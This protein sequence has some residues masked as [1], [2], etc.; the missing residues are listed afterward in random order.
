MN[1]QDHIQFLNETLET[2][3]RIGYGI[4]DTKTHELIKF[5]KNLSFYNEL[6]DFKSDLKNIY[7]L[8]KKE[9]KITNEFQHNLDRSFEFWGEDKRY[10]ITKNENDVRIFKKGP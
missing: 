5:F 8:N 10:P 6:K 3:S 9:W 1:F 2:P 7:K 4:R